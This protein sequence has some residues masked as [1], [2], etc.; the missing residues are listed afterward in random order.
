MGLAE[1]RKALG[2]SQ[3]GLAHVL[4]VDR[5]TVG[6]WESGETEIQ[7]SLRQKYAAALQLD[8]A[9]LDALVTGSPATLPESAGSSSGTAMAQGISTT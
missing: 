3:E 6:R 4:G 1:R 7:P 5:T 2:Y 9:E 8:L